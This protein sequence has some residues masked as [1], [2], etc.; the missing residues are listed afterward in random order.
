MYRLTCPQMWENVPLSCCHQ[1]SYIHQVPPI[2]PLE[3]LYTILNLWG[4]SEETPLSLLPRELI[5]HVIPTQLLRESYLKQLG[6]PLR[7]E[8]GQ[9]GTREYSI[10][11]YSKQRQQ[12]ISDAV[13]FSGMGLT[14]LEGIEV[15]PS[16]VSMM[17]LGYNLLS[18]MVPSGLS[19][20]I[21]SNMNIPAR[22][23]E[24][25]R[26]LTTLHLQDNKL[27]TF[28]DTFFFGLHNLIELDLSFN[29]LESIPP[30]AFAELRALD[31]LYLSG[32]SFRELPPDMLED[33]VELRFLYLSYNLLKEIPRGLF[34]NNKKLK[35]INL[36]N[37]HIEH[38]PLG[39]FHD[40]TNLEHIDIS[41]NQMPGTEDEFRRAHNIPAQV[42]IIFE[43]QGRGPESPMPSRLHI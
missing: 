20:L 6:A 43:P 37:N 34:R 36:S 41:N 1:Y 15:I 5:L 3:S 8:P 33:L 30:A 40:L 17:Y 12:P 25:F 29:A 35:G 22:P 28:P 39:T 24:R 38:I 7:G 42:R 4:F 31:F 14:K 13:Y 26:N 19:E 23:F 10:L 9:L 2:D 32:N 21:D 27:Y 11:D 18:N 16:G